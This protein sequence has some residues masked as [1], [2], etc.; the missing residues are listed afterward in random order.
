VAKHSCS[1]VWIVNDEEK[2]SLMASGPVL[3]LAGTEQV[4]TVLSSVLAR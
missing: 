1:I 3:R 4:R 2:I